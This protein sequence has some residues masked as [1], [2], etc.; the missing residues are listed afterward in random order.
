VNDFN[1]LNGMTFMNLSPFF[2]KS[3]MTLFLGL[4]L[5]PLAQ[6][7]AV[8]QTLETPPSTS[9][10]RTTSSATAPTKESTE[11]GETSVQ[12]ASKV[13][14]L[15]RVSQDDTNITLILP[16]EMLQHI[17]GYLSVHNA[18]RAQRSC[19]DFHRALSSQPEF[20]K[21]QFLIHLKRSSQASSL[22]NR[23]I[24]SSLP[25]SSIECSDALF[26]E[27]LKTLSLTHYTGTLPKK[28]SHF[29]G[30]FTHLHFENYK[31]D[32]SPNAFAGLENLQ[33]L[34]LQENA[35]DSAEIDALEEREVRVKL[36]PK[37]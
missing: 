29:L 32:I 23:V 36:V 2:Q 33:Y 19:F 22:V 9:P 5:A 7:G 10:L 34:Y 20:K 12:S 31:G 11:I 26:P 18:I 21:M 25:I 17:F 14:T 8:P 1:V 35:V 16:Y 28:I 6:S 15:E 13:A 3:F 27:G 37:R 24:A 4:F 30:G